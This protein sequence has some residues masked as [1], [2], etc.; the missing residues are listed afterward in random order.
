MTLREACT[1]VVG[2]L[3]GNPTATDVYEF[4]AADGWRT[5]RASVKST[6]RDLCG[7]AVELAA[8]GEGSY[9]GQRPNRYRPSEAARAWVREGERCG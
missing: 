2:I 3:D 5:S 4:L 1:L 8:Q 6:L 9:G 7:S